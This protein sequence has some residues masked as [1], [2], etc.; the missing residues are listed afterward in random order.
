MR[1]NI[2]TVEN[3][4]TQFKL[5]HLY[6]FT[7]FSITWHRNLLP[8]IATIHEY[9]YMAGESCMG[10]DK[11][12][13][14]FVFWSIHFVWLQ[15]SIY[16]WFKLD[17]PSLYL[18]NVWTRFNSLGS[19]NI[20]Y[21]DIVPSSNLDSLERQKGEPVFISYCHITWIQW[22]YWSYR[23]ATLLLEILKALSRME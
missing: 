8:M 7:S 6:R 3:F 1:K 14:E 11:K 23:W 9:Y 4:S 15:I 13:Q 16:F 12:S 22:K 19:L 2:L 21:F 20:L 5:R 18:P 17:H 10:I